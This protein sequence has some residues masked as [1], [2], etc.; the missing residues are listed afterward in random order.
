MD[1]D[2]RLQAPSAKVTS[3]SVSSHSGEDSGAV[4]SNAVSSNDSKN[5]LASA[6]SSQSQVAVYAPP[7]APSTQQGPGSRSAPKRSL[8]RL[9]DSSSE[10]EKSKADLD[11]ASSYLM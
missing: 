5:A 2:E 4:T 3:S 8:K 7:S 1:L 6:K 9:I 11:D 10:D